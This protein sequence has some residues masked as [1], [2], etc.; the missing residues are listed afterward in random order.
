MFRT[1]GASV[2][3]E[4]LTAYHGAMAG[5][6]LVLED[7]DLLREEIARRY[8]DR[9]WEVTTAATLAEAR[10]QLFERALE[11]LVVISDMNLPDGH[12]LDLLEEVRNRSE[13]G[14]WVILTGYG[15]IPDSV[16]ALR[17]GAFDF[18][19]KPCPGDRLDLAVAGATRSERAQLRLRDEAS[20]RTR[21]Y[22]IDAYVGTSDAAKKLR[23]LLERL[24]RVPLRA[25]ILS[26]E[27]GTGKGLAARILH[28]CGERSAGPMIEINCSAIP[29]DLLESELFG[30]EAGAFTGAVKSQRGLMQ[31]ADG[32]TLFL[33]EISEM[34]PRLQAKLLNALE[35]RRIR[36]VGGETEIPV[37][38]EVI[39]GS[40]RDL[41]ELSEEGSF[42]SDLY[43]RLSVV[44][45][46]LPPLR[47]REGDLE[48]LVPLFVAEF[49]AEAGRQVRVI[50]EEAWAALRGYDWPGNVRELRNVIERSVL[51]AESET[52]PVEWLQLPSGPPA[53]G[54]ATTS[55]SGEELR[56]PLDGSVSLDGIERLVIQQ[57]LER[58]DH[59][60]A[61]AARALGITRQT[62]RYRLAKH[63]LASDL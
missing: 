10:E 48:V 5:T 52:L 39:A 25:V 63:E 59:N 17:L 45:V 9:G 30:H 16:R 58:S 35:D 14:G 4:P 37:D 1:V 62:L 43:H 11:P 12:S 40:N 42:R 20:T 21:R 31:Q 7:E 54:S 23:G 50:P 24:A 18:L 53:A 27:T 47:V 32:G 26:G 33:D 46:D 29:E 55:E 28:H 60:V 22:P 38:F 51:L 2:P 6:L 15:T 34:S 57:A 41:K 56:V 19:E 3:A 49:N 8:R 44:R 61:A 13:G 36:R